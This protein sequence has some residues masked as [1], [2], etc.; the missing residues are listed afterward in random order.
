MVEVMMRPTILAFAT[1][2]LL[3]LALLPAHA[4]ARAPAHASARAGPA[5][6]A[7]R[8]GVDE[9]A[10]RCA[11]AGGHYTGTAC[12]CPKGSR[13]RWINPYVEKCVKKGSRGA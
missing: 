1:T 2:L 5:A 7:K 13:R 10:K 9:F 8:A 4:V 11:K 6:R 3:S 12:E